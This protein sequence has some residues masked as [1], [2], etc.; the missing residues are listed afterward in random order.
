MRKKILKTLCLTSAMALALAICSGGH[1]AASTDYFDLE[2][3]Q[4]LSTKVLSVSKKSETVAEA[5]AAIYVISNE[6]IIRSGVTNIPDALRMVP[7]VNVAQGDSNSWAI[8]IRGF[9][10]GLANKLLVL[11]DGR[12]IYNPVFGG[13]LWEAHDLVLEDIER[14]EVIR[15]PG[16]ALWGA[17]AVNGVI[18]I[19]TK[20]AKDTQGT[21]A[22]ALYGNEELGTLSARHGG[23]FGDHGSYRA[24][25]KGFNRDHSRQLNGEDAYDAWDGYRSGFR[26]DWDNS[27]TFQG[28]IYQ[29]DTDQKRIIHSLVA[30]FSTIE[31][32]TVRYEGANLLTRWTGKNDD[33][34]QLSIQSYIDW[35]RREEAIFFT[36]NRTIYDLEAQYNLMPLG[37]NEITMGAGYRFSADNLKGTWNASFSPQSRNDSLYNA[38]IQNKM[39]LV[40]DALF[41]TLG[42]KFEHNE[43][44]GFEVQPN[45]RLHWQPNEKQSIWAAVSK[46]VRT[47]TPIEDDLTL[48]IATAAGV[49]LAFVPNDNFKTEKLIAY[50]MGYRNQITPAL[51][52]DAAVFYN[53][54][55]GLQTFSFMTPILVNNGVDP[56]H[57]LI[58]AQFRNDMDG[59]SYG[60]ELATSWKA[61]SNF[62]V[63]ANYSFLHLSVDALDS[64]QE[65]AEDLYPSHQISLRTSWNISD[66]WMLD[67]SAHYVDQ[68]HADEVDDYLRLDINLGWQI[69]KNI[70]FN[71]VGQNLIDQAHHEF[72]PVGELNT[73]ESERSVF[74]KL[75]WEF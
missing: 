18:N 25:A 62:K 12:T 65:G 42:S 35:A 11:I 15:G 4:L 54:Y 70:R 13:V 48:T 30:P 44:S 51:S 3:E 66:N 9:N 49:K 1:A 53:V 40:P 17:N 46:A 7:G 52:A 63:T 8:T 68:L 14:I 31:Y 5:P 20:Q 71:L 64:A 60:F 74:G 61:S 2:P 26:A 29:T 24:Y 59:K 67:T 32:P 50:E 73:A 41:L 21:L 16:G 23:T 58:P 22:S 39:T 45:A 57:I 37:R 34:S 38:F 72:G 6:D 10:S 47:P 27:F 19:T 56:L 36:D 75:T 43:Y 28:D 55:D 69:N 33:G